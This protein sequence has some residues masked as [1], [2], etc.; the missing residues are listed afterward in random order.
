MQ[1]AV[2]SLLISSAYFPPQTGGISRYMASVCSTLGGEEM[3]C[4]TGVSSNDR[5]RKNGS[6][7]RVYRRPSA[8][9][10]ARHVQA[11]SLGVS[12]VQ[13]LLRERPDVV[14]IATADDGYIGLW[15]RKQFQ[16]PYVIYAHGNEILDAARSDW[17][18]P[19]ES[20]RRASRVLAVSRFTAA[21]VEETGVNA[22]RIEIVHPGCDIDSF[23]PH[24]PGSLLRKRYLGGRHRGHVILSVG[25]LV[26]RKGHDMV[27]RALPRLLG[28]MEDVTYLIV[29]DGPYRTVLEELASELDVREHVVF[30]GKVPDEDLPDIYALCDVFVLPSREQPNLC[31]IEGFGMVFLEANASGKPVVAG[32]SG[33]VGDA[34]VDGETGLLVDPLDPDGIASSIER[35]LA[36]PRLA[37]RM[38]KQGRERAVREFSWVAVGERLRGIL[39][40]VR[41]EESQAQSAPA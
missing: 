27:I 16:L 31:D 34:V 29:G 35:L 12:V 20:L 3:C 9:A 21:L 4:L 28:A 23:R 32:R 8:F 39:Q 10:K 25:N 11:P 5:D 15:L 1:N 36:T 2:K 22:K 14:Q 30:A 18:K 26:S 37:S 7:P 17:G 40:H 33:G 19:T 6:W 38:G 24:L 41:Q 13:I